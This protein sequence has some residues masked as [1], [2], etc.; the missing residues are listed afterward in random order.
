MLTP[1]H[2]VEGTQ[3]KRKG[4]QWLPSTFWNKHSLKYR[5]LCST[6]DRNSYRFGTT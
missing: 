3:E 1:R 2:Q 6:I 5:H 4:S